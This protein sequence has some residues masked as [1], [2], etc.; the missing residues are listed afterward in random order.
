MN[1]I[2]FLLACLAFLPLIIFLS[3]LIAKHTTG[4]GIA[5]K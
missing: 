4:N 1:N 5:K 3:W 2:D